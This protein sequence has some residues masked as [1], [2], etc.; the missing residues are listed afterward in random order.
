MA[1]IVQE[2][3]CGVQMCA[4]LIRVIP[5]ARRVTMK[6]FENP[7]RLV[8]LT[9]DGGGDGQDS[10]GDDHLCLRIG[11]TVLGA[12][13]IQLS[14]LHVQLRG[15]PLS[16]QLV[17]SIVDRAEVVARRLVQGDVACAA[18]IEEALL[19]SGALLNLAKPLSVSPLRSQRSRATTLGQ[20]CRAECAAY[21]NDGSDQCL[22]Q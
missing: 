6:A 20:P 12:H 13:L 10:V 2:P 5:F 1:E 17:E 9:I 19:P 21:A 22:H 11:S 8:Q 15:I 14:N 7:I 4:D 16:Q 18:Q 3:T